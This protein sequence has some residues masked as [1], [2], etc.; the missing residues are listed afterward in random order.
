RL[1]G[2]APV[3]QHVMRTTGAFSDAA[4]AALQRQFAWL[5]QRQLE[6]HTTQLVVEYVE[7]AIE[8]AGG[9]PAR[10][11]SPPAMLFVDLSGYTALTEK[12]GDEAAAERATVLA[13]TVQ[14][15]AQERG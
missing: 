11:A 15:V 3:R 4:T 12:L 6:H 10:A 8:A 9:A 2:A 5:V 14:E 13:A 7:S 1:A